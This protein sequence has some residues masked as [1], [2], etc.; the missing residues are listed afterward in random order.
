MYMFFLS[1]MVTSKLSR[2]FTRYVVCNFLSGYNY[3]QLKTFKYPFW[4]YNILYVCLLVTQSCP[5]LCDPMDCCPPGSSVHGILQARILEWVAMPFSRGSSQPRD[6]IHVSCITG[7]FLTF[8]V[9]GEAHYVWVC[10][11]VCVCVYLLW[12]EYNSCHKIPAS[13]RWSYQ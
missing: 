4:L 12:S 1:K 5:T 6:W 3:I 8:W 10:V 9:T 2:G 11:C 13:Q 7:E